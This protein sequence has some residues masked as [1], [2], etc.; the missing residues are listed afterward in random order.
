MEEGAGGDFARG[1]VKGIGAV[2]SGPGLAIA[3]AIILK[4]TADLAR[5]GVGSLK[6]FFWFK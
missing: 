6:T 1:I 5:F 3:G 4:L 2:I